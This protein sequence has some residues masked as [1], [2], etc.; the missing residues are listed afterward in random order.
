MA[1]MGWSHRRELTAD[2]QMPWDS[3]FP[4]R[5]TDLLTLF[6]QS[7]AS[8]ER[9][10]HDLLRRAKPHRGCNWG[11]FEDG[12]S[13]GE[14]D[15][16]AAIARFERRLHALAEMRIPLIAIPDHCFEDPDANDGDDPQLA[17]LFKR[18]GAS[19]TALS[20]ADYVF[21][22]IKYHEPRTYEL[23]DN[24][25]RLG[26]LAQLLGPLDIV[27]TAVRLVAAELG[28]SDYESPTMREFDR[29]RMPP[30][31]G[32]PAFM[33]AFMRLI[34]SNDLSHALSGLWQCLAYRGGNDVGLPALA[35]TLISRPVL[36]VLLR[37]MLMR[38]L[39]ASRSPEQ[40]KHSLEPSRQEM[41]RF[42]LYAHVATHNDRLAS[43][44]A[45]EWLV[46]AEANQTDL[47]IFPG[48]Q[49]VH[50]WLDA[51]Q[52]ENRQVAYRLPT[53]EQMAC[54]SHTVVSD[55]SCPM[56]GWTRFQEAE[57][58][59][60][61]DMAFFES[62]WG[63]PRGYRH[64]ILLW[65]QRG[66]VH[67]IACGSDDQDWSLEETVY[68]YDHICPSDEW[69]NWSKSGRG[70]RLL[71]FQSPSDSYGHTILGNAIGNV[72][73][74]DARENRGYGNM[75]A[76]SKLKLA[77]RMDAQ[78][79]LRD[80][81]IAAVEQHLNDWCQSSSDGMHRT[82]S[83][84]RAAAFQRVIEQRTSGLYCR[85]FDD[86]QFEAWFPSSTA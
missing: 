71:D 13:R 56:R 15:P 42:V 60:S 31:D 65:I 41:L 69:S 84:D 80:S 7:P 24:L 82:W 52:H 85:Y 37:W 39:V 32:A 79:I 72:R 40:I 68:D 4:V 44:W 17:V 26:G 66:Y 78:G 75:P 76:S 62:W 58:L 86:L 29:L 28:L 25:S 11:S 27:M 5:L 49:L 70:T 10:V 48:K 38:K 64:P 30:K 61:N 20:D 54:L 36:Q 33:P 74:W 77:D 59:R 22:V 23:V 34:E 3:R 18:V 21:S 50:D 12:A 6:K 43:V 47:E 8:W 9:D 19:G 81:A 57:G 53:K 1:A 55:S 51:V 46:H 73:I 67:T 14:H 63:R 16:V 35:L 83:A 2:D 45:Y